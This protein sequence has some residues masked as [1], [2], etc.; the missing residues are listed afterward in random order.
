M[1][2]KL[3]LT[4]VLLSLA[5]V[6]FRLI[7]V[8]EKLHYPSETPTLDTAYAK[9][10]SG[11]VAGILLD[12]ANQKEYLLLAGGANFPHK[13][14]A[15]GGKKV[16][17]NQ[18]YAYD[19]SVPNGA[20]IQLDTLPEANA[21]AGFTTHNNAL[22][23]VGGTNPKGAS[24][25][26]YQITIQSG[27]AIIQELPTL[28]YTVSGAKLLRREKEFFLLGGSHDGQLSNKMLSLKDN[29]AKWQEAPAYPAEAFIKTLAVSDQK[30]IY[31]WGAFNKTPDKDRELA[32]N[33]TFFIYNPEKA[34]WFKS[35]YINGNDG[36]MEAM[37][38]FGGGMAYYNKQKNEIVF[39][40]G[41]NKE[42]FLPALKRVEAINTA[43]AEHN[44]KLLNQYTEEVRDYLKQPITWHAFNQEA[45][46]YAINGND[47]I[48]FD[49]MN[50]PQ[51][52]FAR[53]DACLIKHKAKFLIIGGELKPGIRT[54]QISLHN[55]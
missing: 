39:L 20:W 40:G 36:A 44:Q 19:L 18:I 5:F 2:K 25:K 33:N 4:A 41:V 53:A 14:A 17:Y 47:L 43:K 29:G 9:G 8:K 21:Y 6:T 35:T 16:F 15:E 32:V 48:S 38:C 13:P 45:Y 3:I 22:Y 30:N 12:E 37:P 34:T 49:K 26:S 1:K 24:N 7:N 51:E 27:K 23:L 10:V 28:P 46:S 11:A 52:S 55:L 50:N 42:R 31:L 54:R